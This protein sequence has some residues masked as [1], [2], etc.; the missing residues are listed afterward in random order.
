MLS[1]NQTKFHLQS[2][3][4]NIKKKQISNASGIYLNYFLNG[5]LVI[6]YVVLRQQK[7]ERDLLACNN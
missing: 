7:P 2:S 5:A 6:T 4:T 1:G 3:Y